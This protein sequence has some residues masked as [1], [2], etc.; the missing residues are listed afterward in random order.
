MS[1]QP[2]KGFFTMEKKLCKLLDMRF[3]KFYTAG[4][5]GQ[6]F[7]TL[8]F[9][10]F[11][12]FWLPLSETNLTY[13]TPVQSTWCLWMMPTAWWCRNSYFKQWIGCLRWK[14]AVI[15]LVDALVETLKME[16]DQDLC[17]NLWYDLKKLLWQDELNPRVRCAFGNV[18]L[19]CKLFLSKLFDKLN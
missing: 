15:F 13:Y 19:F 14:E 17:L 6:R 12:Q 11:Q 16:F 2:L 9:T 5:S 1:Q 10:E 7:Y 3:V 4:F 18:F 8:N